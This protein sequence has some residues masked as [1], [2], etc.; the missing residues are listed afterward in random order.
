MNFKPTS[1]SSNLFLSVMPFKIVKILEINH[2]E[3]DP[4]PSGLNYGEA[5][6]RRVTSRWEGV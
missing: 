5:P 3:L 4:I 6:D 2:S 1:L